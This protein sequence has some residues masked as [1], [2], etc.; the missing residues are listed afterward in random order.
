MLFTILWV[1]V[2]CNLHA[3][4]QKKYTGKKKQASQRANGR[5]PTCCVLIKNT[6][7]LLC[8]FP[9]P[10]FWFIVLFLS[11]F[12]LQ[13]HR[14]YGTSLPAPRT[15]ALPNSGCVT[16]RTTV[17]M[18]SMRARRSAVSGLSDVTRNERSNVLDYVLK[19]M[20][21]SS[22]AWSEGTEIKQS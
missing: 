20:C 4:K 14:A 8:F 21:S 7:S 12:P 6:L 17:R 5:Q 15:S 1:Q 22:R 9:P 2:C 11:H 10:F 19:T 18:A 3:V 16:A 13:T